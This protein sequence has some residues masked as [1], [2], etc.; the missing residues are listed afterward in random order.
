MHPSKQ[1]SPPRFPAAGCVVGGFR[2]WRI[3]ALTHQ[4]G[5]GPDH[6]ACNTVAGIPGGFGLRIVRSGE[7][8]LEWRIA[9]ELTESLAGR[10][11]VLHLPHW[12]FAE[13]KTAFGWSLDQYLF[14]GGYPGAAPLVREHQRWPQLDCG[15]GEERPHSPYADRPRR[16]CRDV[17]AETRAAD[18]RRRNSGG[19][20]SCPTSRALAI[21]M[22]QC[23]DGTSAAR[24][25]N[26]DFRQRDV[27]KWAK[28][29]KIAKVK[30]ERG[31]QDN[32]QSAAVFFDHRLRGDDARLSANV[33]NPPDPRHRARLG[34]AVEH[35]RGVARLHAQGI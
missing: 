25:Q 28:V 10:F 20:V 7:K 5:V 22:M 6:A 15:R 34:A 29:V 18:R 19:G 2:D 24:N 26:I 4:A 8:G 31:G 9:R 12:T 17:Q 30:V 33:S 16:V 3:G 27:A 1:R 23:Q 11:E 35:A 21:W 13:I 14:Y 32:A